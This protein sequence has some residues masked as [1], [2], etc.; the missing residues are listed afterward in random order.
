VQ[1]IVRVQVKDK[2]GGG[3][4]SHIQSVFRARIRGK[5]SCFR[6]SLFHDRHVMPCMII[7]VWNFAL[8]VLVFRVF[9][10][11]PRNRLAGM[12][13]PPGGSTVCE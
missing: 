13:V 11:L 8:T 12:H 4:K 3:I 5:G 9:W 2:G 10:V 7:S 1:A 6:V